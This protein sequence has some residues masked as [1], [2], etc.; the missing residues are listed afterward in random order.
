MQKYK[1]LNKSYDNVKD[2]VDYNS[3]YTIIEKLNSLAHAIAKKTNDKSIEKLTYKMKEDF[4]RKEIERRWTEI[5]KWDNKKNMYYLV[6][7]DG[8]PSIHISN[9]LG[10]FIRKLKKLWK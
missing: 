10:K 4:A 2:T 3:Q 7:P 9:K 5:A 8:T 6:S 1:K